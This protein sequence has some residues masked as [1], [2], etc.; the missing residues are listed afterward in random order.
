M[1]LSDHTVP[2][3]P[4]FADG[5]L[6]LRRVPLAAGSEELSEDWAVILPP[7]GDLKLEP[8]T[9]RNWRIGGGLSN[10]EPRRPETLTAV[11]EPFAIIAAQ[12]GS[13]VRLMLGA[14]QRGNVRSVR[15]ADE[16]DQA[17]PD[18]ERL[19]TTVLSH[20]RFEPL[21]EPLAGE[22]LQRGWL[23]IGR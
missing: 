11:F 5:D 7:V 23:E 13:T 18:L 1:R 22:T 21:A 2:F 17:D 14:D 10:R 12:R 6:G 15:F 19:A 9:L 8:T 3:R 16:E 4:S 20:L